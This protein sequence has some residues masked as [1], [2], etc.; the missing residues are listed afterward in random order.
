VANAQLS[1]GKRSPEKVEALPRTGQ[2][3]AYQRRAS[4]TGPGRELRTGVFS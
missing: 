3:G 1:P 2:A 4:N